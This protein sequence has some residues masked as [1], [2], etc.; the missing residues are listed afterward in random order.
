MDPSQPHTTGQ[1]TLLELFGCAERDDR[2]EMH[3]ASVSDVIP[4]DRTHDG[5]RFGELVNYESSSHL[6]TQTMTLTERGKLIQDQKQDAMLRRIVWD[7]EAFANPQ[8]DHD[9][10]GEYDPEYQGPYDDI[11][12]QIPRGIRLADGSVVGLT[13]APNDERIDLQ[14]AFPGTKEDEPNNI[15]K[16]VMRIRHFFPSIHALKPLFMMFRCR[17]RQRK[18]KIFPLKSQR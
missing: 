17:V 9:A 14:R 2:L 12:S 15:R 7:A 16:I 13:Q 10:K 5:A 8:G 6:A 18:Q 1:S 4:Q 11:R 3:V